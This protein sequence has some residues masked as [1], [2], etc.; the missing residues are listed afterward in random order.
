[1]ASF[2]LPGCATTATPDFTLSA[3]PTTV[4]VVQ[5][6][7]GPST[8][9]VAP[10]GGFTGAVTLTIDTPPSGVSVAFSPN[11]AQ[12]TSILTFAVAA[13]APPGSY[14]V[15]IT[16]TSGPLT[17]TTTVTLNVTAAPTGSITLTGSPTSVT[18]ARG[19]GATVGIRDHSRWRRYRDRSAVGQRLAQ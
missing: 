13:G 10:T 9:A 1:M 3:S 15:T 17:R 11:P 7:N 2:T 8:I 4:N 16:G 14:L 12:S 5:G 6:T 18:L 19:G